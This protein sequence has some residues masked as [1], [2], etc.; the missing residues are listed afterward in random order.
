MKPTEP[1]ARQAAET[2][3]AYFADLAPATTTITATAATAVAMPETIALPKD[4][5]LEM[6]AFYGVPI[7]PSSTHEGNLA[8]FNFP[9]NA[10]ARLFSR[11]GARLTD[12]DGDRRPDHRCHKLC[13]ASLQAAL[14]EIFDVLGERDF[15]D[16]GWNVFGGCWSYRRKTG[17]RSWSTHAWGAAVDLNPG[18]NGW[19]VPT[20]SF[21]ATGIDIMEAHGWLSGGRAWRHDYM[22]FQRAIPNH[23]SPGS[24]YDSHGLPHHISHKKMP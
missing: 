22:H 13:A 24:Y 23:I 7:A 5:A 11:T 10:D 3:A 15:I 6:A 8:W 1:Q 2:L 20:T 14:Q 18:E 9:E 19:K 21:A 17:G 4:T 12:H 16:Q